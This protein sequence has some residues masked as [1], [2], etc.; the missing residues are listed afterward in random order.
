MK[1]GK[2]WEV[3]NVAVDLSWYNEREKDFLNSLNETF[4]I[5]RAD[6]M[7]DESE[8]NGKSMRL[9]LDCVDSLDVKYV[10]E[11][12]MLATIAKLKDCNL[13]LYVLI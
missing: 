5:D 13:K 7:Q 6:D 9:S 4:L 3:K 2:N 12:G 11:Y 1:V 10:K 8:Y